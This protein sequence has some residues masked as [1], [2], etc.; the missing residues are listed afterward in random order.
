MIVSI[1]QPQYLPWVPYFL[2]IAESDLFIILDSVDFQKNGLQNRNRIK[3]AQGG[4]WLTVPVCQK[5]GQKIRDVEIDN[6]IEW[7]KKHWN[8][9]AQ[10]YSKAQSF[11]KYADE[12]EEVYRR[13]WSLL[14]DLDM[15][16]LEMMVHWMEIGTRMIRSSEMKTVGK[17]SGLV[18]GLCREV[19]ATRYLSG[20]G[21]RS[22]LNEEAFQVAGVELVYRAPV[23][24][25]TYP[26]RHSK[27]GF[28]NDLSALDIVLNC[29]DQWR[30]YV[31]AGA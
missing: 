16:I 1:H 6:T 22:Y 7:R 31:A 5:L 27:V 13:D 14:I 20:V 19:G 12:L 4:G 30:K 17:G 2:K 28:L 24:P 8:S 10:N 9:I 11:G 26:Q 18:L 15:H 23:L 3:T 29:G 21:A 25:D